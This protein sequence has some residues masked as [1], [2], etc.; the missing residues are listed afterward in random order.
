MKSNLHRVGRSL[1]LAALLAAGSGVAM[2]DYLFE[3]N[4]NNFQFPEG[5]TLEDKDGQHIASTD[6]KNG[7]TDQAWGITTVDGAYGAAVSLSHS[8]T[9]VAQSNLMTLPPLAITGDA[10][11]LRWKARTIHADFPEAYRVTAT[12]DGQTQTLFETEA[13]ASV[14]TDRVVDL[15]PF[16]G[17]QVTLAFEC[18]ST[19]K[20]IL[21]LDDIK[22]GDPEETAFAT[23]IT[24]PFY[25]G[26]QETT[27][28]VAGTV[29][30]I[31]RPL[32]GA[33]LVA[34]IGGAVAD[35]MVLPDNWACGQSV[36]FSLRVPA[37]L[38][39][40]TDYTLAV[41]LGD[42][43]FN[44]EE[45]GRIF[46]S[47]YPRTL[48]VEDYTGLWCN[49]CPD[50]MLALEEMERTYGRQLVPLS[51][52]INDVLEDSEYRR[53]NN[54]FSVPWLVLNRLSNTGGTTTREF[55]DELAYPTIS[56]IELTDYE[57]DAETL[58]VKANVAWAEDLNNSQDRYRIGFILTRDVWVNDNTSADYCQKN[59][60]SS[61][62]DE[63]FYYLPTLIMP[64]LSPN[65]NV[66]LTPEN[67]FTGRAN[68]LPDEMKA[69]Q[70]YEATWTMK[71]PEALDD[72]KNGRLVAYI[73]DYQTRRIMNACQQRLD[74]EVP[75]SIAGPIVDSTET[76]GP[77]EYYTIDGLR[78]SEP[79]GGI[80]IQRQGTKA[81]KIIK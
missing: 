35:A 9:E 3:C 27:A 1:A 11:V 59:S 49:N 73:V 42:D 54:I 2:A 20:Y 6:Y 74:E 47:Y 78:V 18:F 32:Q 60:L 68:T 16:A 4:F 26:N 24:S 51:V 44:L 34:F 72:F 29:T 80:Y 10:P 55:T 30:N 48:L 37:N 17:K 67:T 38:N 75:A 45:A 8:R 63:R 28:P 5:V 76:D 52:H 40:Y 31:G 58:T 41:E 56:F 53:L 50:G 61:M 57:Y 14:W 81:V 21:A 19:N 7:Y 12:V 22:V 62:S 36:D 70:F 65:K 64:D 71:K 33:R 15:S 23:S 66:V 43:T 39:Q 13:E 77:V 69:R 25:V 46:C 79:T